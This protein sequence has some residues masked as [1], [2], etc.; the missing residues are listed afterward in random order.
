MATPGKKID[1][2]TFSTKVREYKVALRLDKHNSMFHAEF[3]K[4]LFSSETVRDL[5]NQLKA[6]AENKEKLSFGWFIR[7]DVD[8]IT[9]NQDGRG[10]GW[11]HQVATLSELTNKL[12]AGET[13]LGVKFVF[14]VIEVS[15]PI[16][17]DERTRLVREVNDVNGVLV[18]SQKPYERHSQFD[19]S[20]LLA[21][22]P[23]RYDGLVA[24]QQ[25]LEA[26]YRALLEAVSGDLENTLDK[27]KL[28]LLLR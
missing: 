21:F 23:R 18:A 5:E 16:D 13:M 24:L 6:A 25:R 17:G 2:I 15:D 19:N 26:L 11:S 1:T 12:E 22:T 28:T 10:H 14:D 20:N 9:G 27:G 8:I 4:E 7:Y 3:E